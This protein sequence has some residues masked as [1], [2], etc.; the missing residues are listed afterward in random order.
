MAG[1]GGERRPERPDPPRCAEARRRE[2]RE[3]P[4]KGAQMRSSRFRAGNPF[5]LIGESINTNRKP[6]EPVQAVQ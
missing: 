6:P 5:A 1:A 4:A 3:G 2:R